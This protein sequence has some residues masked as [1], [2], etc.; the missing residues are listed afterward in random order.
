MKK[1]VVFLV[2][3]GVLLGGGY[4]AYRSYRHVRQARLINQARTFL[5]KNNTRKAGLALQRALHYNTNDVEACRLMARLGEMSHSPAAIYWRDRVVQLAPNSSAD[6]IA[7]AQTALALREPAF[8]AHAL[9]GVDEASKKTAAYLVAAGTAAAEAGQSSLA[10]TRL[11]EALRLEPQNN[12]AQMNLAVVRIASSNQTVRAQAQAALRSLTTSATNAFLR[13]Q[14]RREL[15][16]DALHHKELNTALALSVELLQD[17]N[18]VFQDRILRLE[19]LQQANKPEFKSTLAAT[20][21]DAASKTNANEVYEL[22]VWQLANVPMPETLAWLRSV[23][24]EMQTNVSVAMMMAEAD[25]TMQNWSTVSKNLGTQNWG[26]L[27]A[28][29]HAF[30]CRAARGADNNANAT[31]AALGEWELALKASNY[32]KVSLAMLLTLTRRWGWAKESEELLWAIV[33]RYPHEG[34]MVQELTRLLFNNGRTR[35]MMVLCGQ[36]LKRAP[37]RLELKKNLAL[38]AL[39]VGDQDVR[40]HELAREVYE[41]APAN[42]AYAATYAFSLLIQRKNAEALQVMQKLPPQEVQRPD[43]AGY[44]GLTLQANGEAA[45]AKPFLEIG[46]KRPTLPEERK[47]FETGRI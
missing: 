15:L 23:P 36:Q 13:C 21:R 33:N 34:T 30:L 42:P 24:M 37:D 9:E 5:D 47:L 4:A 6:K 14:A 41:K 43:V 10:E 20:Q 17:T 22:G 46:L 39:L 32:Q 19:T 44:Y 3:L 28:L 1:V 26:E 45:K 18:S 25:I 16:I 29:R 31:G 38:L 40:P 12:T 2:V 11:T 27:E 8:A 7:L 35:S